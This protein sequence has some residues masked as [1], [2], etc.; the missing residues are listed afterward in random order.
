MAFFINFSLLQHLSWSVTRVATRKSHVEKTAIYQIKKYFV[1][2]SRDTWIFET[3]SSASHFSILIPENSC[4][5]PKEKY[6][7]KK[8]WPI[9]FTG[10]IAVLYESWSIRNRKTNFW[11]KFHC[12][13]SH[14]IT[15]LVERLW[16]FLP[17]WLETLK[18]YA[19]ILATSY[20]TTVRQ[21]SHVLLMPCHH[22]ITRIQY[23]FYYLYFDGLSFHFLQNSDQN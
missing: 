18:L 2:T 5:L 7:A 13:I 16:T 21:K 9:Y 6:L 15:I 11:V 8:F 1:F 17:H 12:K 10:S 20:G 22:N 14:K 23:I 3:M 4:S 19:Y